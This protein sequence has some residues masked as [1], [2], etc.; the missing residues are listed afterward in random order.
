MRVLIYMEEKKVIINDKK[1][2]EEVVEKQLTQVKVLTEGMQ[3]GELALISA[4]LKPRAAT[5]VC[6]EECHLAVL[7]KK[8]FDLILSSVRFRANRVPEDG[9]AGDFLQFHQPLQ[10]LELQQHQEARLQR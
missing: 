2:E 9:V 7:E 4:V 10:S 6:Q 1:E 8:Y 5:I 3:F